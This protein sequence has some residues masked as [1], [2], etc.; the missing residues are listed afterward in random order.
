LKNDGFFPFDQQE[1]GDIL[2]ISLQ[3]KDIDSAP[4][5]VAG[6]LGRAFLS[7]QNVFI[8]PFTS[9]KRYTETL[10]AAKKADTVIISLF[11]QRNTYKDYGPLPE[12]ELDFLRNVFRAKPRRTVVMSYGNPYHVSDVSGAAAFVV[13]Y[14]EGGFYGN[15]TIYA[16]SFIKLMKGDL[17]PSGKLPILISD[18][19][20]LGCGVVY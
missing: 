1:A 20:P 6:K 10:K 5:V 13:G 14:G 2:H 9:D 8:R 15:Q 17:S 18:K 11:F 7:V 12:K 19:Y 16:D 4:A 3:K